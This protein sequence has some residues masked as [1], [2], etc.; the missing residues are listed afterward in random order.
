MT[1]TTV[2]DWCKAEEI[3]YVKAIQPMAGAEFGFDVDVFGDVVVVGS[4][5]E[6]SCLGEGEGG[7]RC[8]KSGAVFVFRRD[9]DNGEY[10]Q[11]SFL[12]ASNA[13]AFHRF[14]NAVAIHG[15][16]IVVGALSED[17][18]DRDNP[19]DGNCGGSGSAYVFAYNETSKA[20]IEEDYLKADIIGNGDL[21]GRVVD[22]FDDK[23]L[24]GAEL[25]DSCSAANPNDNGCTDAGSAYVFLLNETSLLPERRRRTWHKWQQMAY[26]KASNVGSGDKLGAAVSLFGDVAV[27]GATGEDGCSDE[28]NSGKN[29][30]SCGGA[31]AVY[32]YRYMVEVGQW[33]EEAYLKAFNSNG[34][35]QFGWRVSISGNLIAVGAIGEAS[36]SRGINEENDEND[37]ACF[38]AGA[39]YIFKF[40]DGVGWQQEAYIKSSNGEIGDYFGFSVSLDGNSLIA[41]AL[42]EDSCSQNK[43]DSNSCVNAGSAF[44]F[45]RKS[46]SSNSS[47]WRQEKYLKSSNVDGGDQFGFSCSLFEEGGMVVCG[48][49]FEDSCSTDEMNNACFNAGA[50]YVFEAPVLGRQEEEGRWPTT[51]PEEEENEP[52]SRTTAVRKGGKNTRESLSSSSSSVIIIVIVVIVV[53][54]FFI[55]IMIVLIVL[56]VYF[57]KTKKKGRQ[58]KEGQSG[59]GHGSRSRSRHRSPR[60]PRPP[61]YGELSLMRAGKAEY[62][63]VYAI[64]DLEDVG[65]GGVY[66]LGEFGE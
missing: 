33:L 17:S 52:K 38:F 60:S 22:I 39:V 31:G 21:F 18:C 1:S 28:V 63:D 56:I 11:E 23:I 65:E 62:G 16:K 37:N 34:G 50:A 35:D 40:V 6:S 5:F 13:G 36:C 32:V 2:V 4:P 64:G 14:G 42:R 55:F 20:W 3:A 47:L 43:T 10:R 44:V 41:S 15:R 54:F 48:G 29:D 30:D 8:S 49:H 19:S 61:V 59:H 57:N 51:N 66:A 9:Q 53:I 26:L 7:T 27:V 45:Y 46:S 24:V 12:K 25:E 58:T